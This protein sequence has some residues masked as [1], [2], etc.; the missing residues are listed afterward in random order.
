M[1]N[2]RDYINA[3]GFLGKM[4][5]AT[6]AKILEQAGYMPSSLEVM[7]LE[8]RIIAECFAEMMDGGVLPPLNKAAGWAAEVMV[9]LDLIEPVALQEAQNFLYVVFAAA[10]IHLLREGVVARIGDISDEH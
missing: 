8:S 7:E 1:S 10:Q 5:D 6:F 3:I 9:A 4:E 2:K